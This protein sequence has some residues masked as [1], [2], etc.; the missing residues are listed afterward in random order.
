MSQ[1]LIQVEEHNPATAILTLNRPEK[2]NAL[3]LALLEQIAAAVKA[4]AG[5]R[6]CRVLIICGAGPSFCSGLDLKEGAEPNNAERS[7]EA[8]ANL[9]EAV[10]LSPL[11]TIAAAH[12][13]AAGGG[14]GLV[15]ACDFVV[16]SE[17]FKLAFP[18]VHRGLV[19]ALV[20]ALL[21]RQVSDRITRELA[22][23]GG[24]LESRRA[25][26]L[27]LANRIVSRTRLLDEALELAQQ[28]CLGAP[29]AIVRSKRLLD[30][31]SARPI[32]D[33]LR[34]ALRY[35]LEARNST[36]AEEGMRAFVEKRKPRW[37]DREGDC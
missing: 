20:T 37:G 28:V 2:R 30:E 22:L 36:E 31:T 13:T 18:E 8:L 15:M 21:R 26:E 14:A 33:E 1:S 16:A 6:R 9:Y 27:G 10:C 12:G 23:L 17:D 35:H 5:D 29:N 34:G 3:S 7:A 25:A 32:R 19:A 24:S 4:A 11:V